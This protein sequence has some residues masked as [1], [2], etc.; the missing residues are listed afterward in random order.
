MNS[1]FPL[2]LN[3]GQSCARLDSH[4]AKSYPALFEV[5]NHLRLEPTNWPLEPVWSCIDYYAKLQ[6]AL[7][8]KSWNEGPKMK[9]AIL[10]VYGERCDNA[11]SRAKDNSTLA[12]LIRDETKPGDMLISFNYETIA[13]QI[14]RKHGREL[15]SAGYGA[16]DL[17]LVKPHGSTSWTMDRTSCLL[18]W[19]LDG[20]TPLLKSLNASD[21]DAG[22]EPLLLGAVPIKS[23]LIKEVQERYQF[24]AIFDAITE[25]WRRVF[26]AFRDAE[27]IV[28]SQDTV[29]RERICT[30]SFL[31]TR[32]CDGAIALK[33]FELSFLIWNTKKRSERTNWRPYFAG[34]FG[35]WFSEDGSDRPWPESP[36]TGVRFFT[37]PPSSPTSTPDRDANPSPIQTIS[38]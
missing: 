18:R 23:E 26:E 17:V 38:S 28:F 7:P 35:N 5:V 16:K 8:Q 9:R 25:Q 24:L 33:T 2:P 30:A 1:R 15:R 4:W 31:F 19:K 29:F 20:G 12:H 32:D 36:E 11:A 13:E 3:L 6:K 34:T 21:V 10:A 14:A 27:T 22:R 37:H